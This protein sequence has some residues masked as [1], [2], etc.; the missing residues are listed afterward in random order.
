[1]NAMLRWGLIVLMI[2][3]LAACAQPKRDLSEAERQAAEAAAAE[4]EAEAA[5][6]A[7]RDAEAQG[8]GVDRDL[9]VDP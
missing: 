5:E 4:T 9:S 3:L 1:M 6:R 2:G 8:L 7:R